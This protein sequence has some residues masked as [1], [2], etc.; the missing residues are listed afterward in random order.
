MRLTHFDNRSLTI[1]STV[2]TVCIGLLICLGARMSLGFAAPPPLQKPEKVRLIIKTA[3]GLTQAQ[4][5]A[6]V[7]GHGA[8]PKASVPKLDLHIIEVPEQAADAITKAMKGDAQIL[9]VESDHTRKW[10]G[11]P[12][13]TQYSSQWALPKIAWNQV[14]G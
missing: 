3:K 4:A 9:R 12:S 7:K 10:Q 5:E 11:A 1:S 8:T 14:Y 13:D 2:A 6:V